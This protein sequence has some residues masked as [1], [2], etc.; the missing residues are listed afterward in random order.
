MTRRII[1]LTYTISE[2]MTTYPSYWHPMVEITQLGRHHIEERETRKIV[3]G[4]HTGTHIDAP[5]HF[6][7]NGGTIDKLP[8]ELFVGPAVILD[9]S[10]A[11]PLQEIQT[12]DFKRAIGEI[13][14][15][16][17]V[18]RFDWSKHWGTLKFY[19]DYPYISESAAHWLI[20]HGV[21]LLAMD[22]PQADSP[23]NCKGSGNDS[24]IH[25]ILLG[26]NVIMV[27]YLCNLQ[28]LTKKD[29]ELIILPMKI[30]EG[31]G[32]PARCIAIEEV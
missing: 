24:P 15:G 5:R 16:R 28:A 27:E 30:Q 29:I 6:V 7:P 22:T 23:R 21:K 1:D 4:T 20:D 2:G 32:S 12:E 3:L 26:A 18:M 25:K 14:Y 10:Y 8:L 19:H 13:N 11:K 17:I 9:F 31:D